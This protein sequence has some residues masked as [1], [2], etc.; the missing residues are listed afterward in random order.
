M[1]TVIGCAFIVF[2]SQQ[3]QNKHQA[4]V[5][6][7]K[8][9]TNLA[10]LSHTRESPWSFLYVQSVRNATTSSQ[11]SSVRPSRSVSKR[12]ILSCVLHI[13]LDHDHSQ[14]FTPGR[15]NLVGV[16][17][18]L[19]KTLTLFMNSLQANLRPNSAIFFT[20]FMSY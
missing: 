14:H 13:I 20:L 6:Y 3:S 10:S 2:K 19:P 4:R 18:P 17:S 8:L 12:L 16:C 9:L 7:N 15:K 11:Y 5:P 1:E